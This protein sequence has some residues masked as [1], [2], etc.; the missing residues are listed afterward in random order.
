QVVFRRALRPDLRQA[1]QV[2]RAS[3]LEGR[4]RL[5]HRRLWSRWRF[6]ASP[7][8]D[9]Q[10]NAAADRLS[11]PLCVRDADRRGRLYH[12]VHV[13]GGDALMNWPILSVVTF[14]PLFRALLVSLFVPA[15][16]PLAPRPPPPL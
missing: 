9:A 16:H 14:L 2:A 3:A 12:L 11:L 10:R 1:D 4:R 7:R 13:F 6:G 15:P 8:C 5:A